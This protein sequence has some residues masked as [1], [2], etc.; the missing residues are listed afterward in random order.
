[1][2]NEFFNLKSY[3]GEQNAN[4]LKKLFVDF[5]AASEIM[6]NFVFYDAHWKVRV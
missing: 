5:Y 3:V 1:M 2:N 6:R 4:K